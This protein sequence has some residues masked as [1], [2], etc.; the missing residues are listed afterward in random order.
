MK[1]LVLSFTLFRIISAPFVFIISIFLDNY[2]ATFWLFSF[3]ALSDYLDGKLAREYR[4]ESRLG[5]I[6]DPIGDKVLILFAT[7]SVIIITQDIFVAFMVACILAREF[8]SL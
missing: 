5:A 7:I 8:W 1:S 4:V 3:A 6:L 2:W